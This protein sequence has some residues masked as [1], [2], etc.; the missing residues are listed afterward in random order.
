MSE[1]AEN[2]DRVK[3]FVFINRTVTICEVV[4]VLEILF[5]S[6]QSISKDN[7]YVCHIA[8]KFVSRLLRKDQKVIVLACARI[9][10]EV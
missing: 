9:S 8:T 3:E 1:K 6:V 10:R 2:V 7:L 5:W 4:N